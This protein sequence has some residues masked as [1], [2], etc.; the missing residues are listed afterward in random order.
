MN[1]F[2][3]TFTCLGNPLDLINIQRCP[4]DL[5]IVVMIAVVAL[6]IVAR[7][8]VMCLSCT[9]SSGSTVNVSAFTALLVRLKNAPMDG[10]NEMTALKATG[11]HI[12]HTGV[13]VTV[14]SHLI[15]EYNYV[16]HCLR[17][18]SIKQ[19]PAYLFGLQYKSLLMNLISLLELATLIVFLIDMFSPSTFTNV[20][21]PNQVKIGTISLAAFW[22][23]IY[24][25]VNLHMLWNASR[26]YWIW[27]YNLPGVASLFGLTN[28]FFQ[29][30]IAELNAVGFNQGN[31]EAAGVD[32]MSKRVHVMVYQDN[33]MR[34]NNYLS[35]LLAF[36]RFLFYAVL[37]IYFTLSLIYINVSQLYI[38]LFLQV[39]IYSLMGAYIAI[40]VICC[41]CCK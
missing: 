20:I 11:Y 25:Y 17:C 37:L 35:Q 5:I 6:W 39:A 9:R 38:V 41:W 26:N 10:D 16:C 13:A 19:K 30:T 23:L 32:F 34:D 15:A 4:Y 3:D 2:N 1:N 40:R 29:V 22:V 21:N 12:K 31:I 8:I 18:T 28:T 14:V 7:I 33:W 24:L 27:T 36:H